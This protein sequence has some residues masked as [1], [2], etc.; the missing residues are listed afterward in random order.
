MPYKQYLEPLIGEF[1]LDFGGI[2]ATRGVQKNDPTFKI[3]LPLKL[4]RS[5][6]INTKDLK[7]KA[8]WAISS[9]LPPYQWE[10][11]FDTIQ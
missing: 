9:P 4:V 5:S 10:V 7:A 1:L 8:A 2:I 6:L 11:N 3:V